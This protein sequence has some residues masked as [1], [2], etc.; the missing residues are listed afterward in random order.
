MKLQVVFAS[1]IAVVSL[2]S[3]ALAQ[4]ASEPAAEKHA[5]A[6]TAEPVTSTASDATPSIAAP[7]KAKPK[8]RRQATAP[9]P[10]PMPQPSAMDRFS[11]FWRGGSATDSG[12]ARPAAPYSPSRSASAGAPGD[13]NQMMQHKANSSYSTS[14]NALGFGLYRITPKEVVQFREKFAPGTILVRQREKRLYYVNG[15]GTAIRYAIAV[16][17]EGAA[18]SGTSTVSDK[19]EWPGWTPTPDILKRQPDLPRHVDGGPGNP[20]GAR[21]LY[22]GQTMYR[23]HG[24]NEPWRI[25]E[26]ASSGC[27][28]MTNDDVVDL[29]NR[30][31]LGATVIVTH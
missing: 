13:T 23:I 19:K 1:L 14:S 24:T 18:W 15:D 3:G 2:Q 7:E 30:T 27:I 21:A 28:R 20:L 4:S 10:A 5:A 12:S 16:G 31:R 6:T 8:V 22:L 26:E 9:A 29:Y 25:G 17:R 11:N